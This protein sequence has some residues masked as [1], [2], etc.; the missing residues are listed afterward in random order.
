MHVMLLMRMNTILELKRVARKIFEKALILDSSKAKKVSAQRLKEN[1]VI[2]N[3]VLALTCS[4]DMNFNRV[5]LSGN[6][7]IVCSGKE[8]I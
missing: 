1:F 6:G 4:L 2:E 5:G 3:R 8:S 7:R